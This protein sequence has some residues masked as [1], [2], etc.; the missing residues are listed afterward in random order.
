M[1]KAKNSGLRYS[2]STI[3]VS[4]KRGAVREESEMK[5]CEECD[6]HEKAIPFLKEQ[7]AIML[8]ATDNEIEALK[9]KNVIEN[10]VKDEMVNLFAHKWQPQL[11]PTIY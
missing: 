8:A 1:N 11:S 9:A 6:A 5:L 2:H 3:E 7:F 4:R 10:T